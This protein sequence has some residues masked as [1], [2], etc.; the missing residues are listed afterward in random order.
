MRHPATSARQSGLIGAVFRD[1][2]Q[3]VL[4]TLALNLAKEALLSSLVVGSVK[5]STAGE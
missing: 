4:A 5:V 1:V 2:V 3:A